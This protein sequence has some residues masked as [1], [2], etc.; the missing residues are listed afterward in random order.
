MRCTHH[1]GDSR[2]VILSEGEDIAM[3]ATSLSFEK[4]AI[5]GP[6]RTAC[7]FSTILNDSGKARVLGRKF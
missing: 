3:I 2:K 1:I 4:K 6:Y 7:W 5:R